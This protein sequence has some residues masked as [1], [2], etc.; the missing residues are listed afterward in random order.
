VDDSNK[1]KRNTGARFIIGYCLPVM[2]SVTGVHVIA[3]YKSKF[4]YLLFTDYNN[5][6]ICTFVSK[7]F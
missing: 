4:T 5:I 6:T 2:R 1:H 3:Q 7:M